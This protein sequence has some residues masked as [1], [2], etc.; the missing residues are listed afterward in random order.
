MAKKYTCR[1]VGVD[2]DW[3]TSGANEDDVMTSIGEH[4]ALVHPTIELTPDLLAAVRRVIKD[5]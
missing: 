5:E 2:C 1:D 3:K 4:A